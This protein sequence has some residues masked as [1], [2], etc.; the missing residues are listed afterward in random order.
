[1][2]SH[3]TVTQV[4]NRDKCHR[5]VTYITSSCNTEKNIKYFETNN[6]I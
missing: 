2:I 1:M 4:T 5:V 3:M 6:L